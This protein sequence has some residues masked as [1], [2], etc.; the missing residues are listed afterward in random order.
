MK[1]LV[2]YL[3][4]LT[5]KGGD[6]DGAPFKVLPWER[7]FIRR[8]FDGSPDDAALSVARGDGK[9]A[10]VA[11]LASAVV[12]PHGP[13]HATRRHVD[14]FASSFDQG[15]V[16]FEDILA[17]LG[18]QHDL[19]DRKRWRKQYTANRAWL[20]YKP[21]GARARVL[22]SDPKRAHGLRSWLALC[23]EP[24]QWDPAKK[25]RMLAAIRTGLGKSPGSRLIAL[26]TRPAD[27]G[28]W[29]ARML[30]TAKV[31][32]VHAAAPDD[33]PFQL[34]TIRKAN[35]SWDHLPSLRDRI[36]QEIAEA[37]MDPDALASFKALRLNLGTA[38]I[39]EQV[40]LDPDTY[41]RIEAPDPI[42]RRGG[43]ALGIDTGQTAA[44][45]AAAGFWPTTGAA[46]AFAVFPSVPSLTERGLRDAVG[47]TYSE[48]HKRGE[49]VIAGHYVSDLGE[50]LREVL[51]RWGKPGCIVVDRHR[52]PELR[53]KLKDVG[54]PLVPFIIRGMGFRDGAEDVRQFRKVAIA[55][56]VRPPVSLLIRHAIGGARVIVNPAG[57]WKLAKNSEGGRRAKLRDDAAAA[58]ILAVAEGWRRREQLRAVAKRPAVRVTVL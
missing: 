45:T 38:D 27:T 3:E 25:D 7:R 14:C 1:A 19:E 42:E 29:F 28:H 44:M 13:L 24:A 16:V 51:R 31:A 35:P 2:D 49:L 4:T 23:D 30:K 39:V 33:P 43:Y 21:T 5:L 10:L 57:D 34:R 9:S 58:L 26:G 53:E 36:K 47:R 17:F 12:D 37:R 50:L 46:D 20:E 54:F 56:D 6:H 32:Q 52:A 18:E 11:G 41:S 55:A 40:L 22:G 48:M 8:A 15:L